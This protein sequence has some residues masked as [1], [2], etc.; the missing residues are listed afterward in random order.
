MEPAP[1]FDRGL[2]LIP[3]PIQDGIPLEP[4]ALALLESASKDPDALILIE[5]HKVARNRWIK[6]GLSRESID[7]FRPFNEHTEEK[8]ITGLI[9]ELRSGK[10]AVLMSDGGLPAFYDPGRK[11]VHAC[12][13][14]G[15]KVTATP[16]PNSIALSI[17]L[18][19]FDHSEFHF[20]G[21][22]PAESDLRKKWLE[23]I[24]QSQDCTLVMMDTPYRLQSLLKDLAAS[25]LKSRRVFLAT[26]LNSPA[27]RLFRGKVSEMLKMIGELNKVEF[28]IVLD[29]ARS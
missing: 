6:W 25:P 5:D 20:C 8:A 18:S 17:A 24:S 26:E 23:R 15:I 16:F 12:H 22:P 1:Q 10:R 14:A 11:L 29:G 7:R 4:V 9:Q 19:G 21:F 3:T 2:I 27:E 28:V 13:E